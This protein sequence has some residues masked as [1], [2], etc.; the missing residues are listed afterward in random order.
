MLSDP[1]FGIDFIDGS[2]IRRDVAFTP[3]ERDFADY[4][5]VILKEEGVFGAAAGKVSSKEI[6]IAERFNKLLFLQRF[7]K[8]LD[9]ETQFTPGL[10]PKM[11]DAFERAGYRLENEHLDV[12]PFEDVL[13]FRP[14]R[15]TG[16]Q[17]GSEW[18]E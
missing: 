1:R 7:R 9:R 15:K 11:R 13:V 5:L 17:R 16:T 6:R 8:F 2:A 10:T 12:M 4:L 14:G 3:P 18:Q